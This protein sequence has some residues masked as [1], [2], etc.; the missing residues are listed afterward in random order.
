MNILKK[1][2][3]CFAAA[4]VM[5]S[6]A[7]TASADYAVTVKNGSSFTGTGEDGTGF[8]MINGLPLDLLDK[9]KVAT[10]A[11]GISFLDG[12]TA[13]PQGIMVVSNASGTYCAVAENDFQEHL[14]YLNIFRIY[15]NKDASGN[16]CMFINV[17]PISNDDEYFKIFSKYNKARIEILTWA[18][19]DSEEY[20]YKTEVIDVD[21]QFDM[22]AEATS[23]PVSEP[24]S[25]PVSEPADEPTS[26]EP[27]SEPESSEPTT[28][29]PSNVDTGTA[30]V[31]AVIGTALLAAGAVIVTRKKNK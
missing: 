18:D 31:A 2:A 4:A 8:M 24:E 30:G 11:V 25:E 27:V 19:A 16:D 26:S 5:T 1:A 3:A 10:Y 14:E 20:D 15:K 6:M 17:E 21:W 28:S 13:I 23:E 29:Q 7:V 9:D 22:N 12:D